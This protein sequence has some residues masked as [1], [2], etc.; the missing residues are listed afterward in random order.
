MWSGGVSRFDSLNLLWF[1]FHLTIIAQAEAYKTE[2]QDVKEEKKSLNVPFL[3][4]K[5]FS[6]SFAFFFLFQEC[7]LVKIP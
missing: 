4:G 5:Q 2:I 6:K 1:Q 7:L 3:D